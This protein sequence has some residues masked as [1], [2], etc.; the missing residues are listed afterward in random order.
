[1]KPFASV[2]VLFIL[3]PLATAQSWNYDTLGPE[4]W[5]DLFHECG[6]T[7]QSPIN[8]RTSCTLYQSYD[9]LWFSPSYRR[10]SNF[11]LVNDGTTIDGIPEED[12]SSSFQLTGGGLNGTFELI[13]F[14]L[15]WGENYRSGSEHQV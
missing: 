12:V 15:H 13:D 5:S 4:V 10:V 11:T 9:H 3:F 1:M 2:S 6:R 7:S 14:H 8:I